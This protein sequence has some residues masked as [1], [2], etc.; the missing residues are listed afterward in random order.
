VDKNNFLLSS[1]YLI[2]IAVSARKNYR[3]ENIEA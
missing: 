3:K 2:E 1:K